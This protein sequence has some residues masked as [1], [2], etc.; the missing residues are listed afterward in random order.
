MI[1]EGSKFGRFIVEREVGR[2]S[3]GTVYRAH[4][5]EGNK[6]VAIKLLADNL[7]KDSAVLTMFD[8]EAKAGIELTHPNIVQTLYVGR[9]ESTPY[10]VFEFV[11]GLSLGSM[12]KNG[13][14]PQTHCLWILRQ[15]AQALRHLRQKKIVHQ[16]IKPENI[17]IDGSGNAKLTDLGFAKVPQGKISWTGIAAGTALY[18][19]PEQCRGLKAVDGR[20]DIYSLG[21]TIYHAATGAPPF[22]SNNEIELLQMHLT[23]RPDAA[24]TRNPA[25]NG[26]FSAILTRML[27]KDPQWRYQDPEELLLSLRLLEIEPTSPFISG[28]K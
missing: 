13:P 12:L 11:D 16:D 23:R 2:G 25:L 21:A 18:I 1:P 3:N 7:A 9:Y 5:V 4:S 19:S 28:T 10:I 14:L 15:L 26:D 20:A 17:L 6:T 27:E 22:V 8:E 24:K